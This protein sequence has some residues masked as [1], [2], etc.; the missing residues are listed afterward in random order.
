M[1]P[2]PRP[3]SDPVAGL[4]AECAH[5]RRIESHRRSVFYLCCRSMSD[6]SFA[7]YPRL[8]VLACS[9]FEPPALPSFTNDH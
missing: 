6:P 8:P 3:S 5:A 9:G 7:K 4:C 2:E 1:K